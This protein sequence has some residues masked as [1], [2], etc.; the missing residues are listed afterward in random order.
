MNH[1]LGVVLSTSDGAACHGVALGKS[2]YITVSI[3]KIVVTSE[4]FN[5]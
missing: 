1:D 4:R 2:L 3:Y 5:T